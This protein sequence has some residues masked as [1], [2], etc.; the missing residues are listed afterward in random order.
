MK[1]AKLFNDLMGDLEHAIEDST[2]VNELYEISSRLML[3]GKV[4]AAFEG[5]HGD[6]FKK[7][8]KLQQDIL[9][10]I[11]VQFLTDEVM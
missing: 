1:E 7:V 10:K 2:E 8:F 4:V 5:R 3:I 9:T 6:C 11:N